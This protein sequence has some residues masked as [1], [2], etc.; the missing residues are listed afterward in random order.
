MIEKQYLKPDDMRVRIENGVLLYTPIVTVD[1][2]D[3]AH[4]FLAGQIP[5]KPDGTLIGENDMRAQ[6]RATCENVGKGLRH[7]GADFDDVVKSTTYVTNLDLYLKHSDERYNFFKNN[8]PPNTLIEISK[9]AI[10]KAMIE[11]TVE[12]IIDPKNLKRYS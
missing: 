9:L 12:A 2:S 4:I 3:H 6:I 7:A 11:I 10:E 5:V 1:G 8:R